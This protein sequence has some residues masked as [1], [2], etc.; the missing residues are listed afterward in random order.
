MFLHITCTKKTDSYDKTK[1]SRF[2]NTVMTVKCVKA[3]VETTTNNDWKEFNKIISNA[4][5]RVHISFQSKILCN[6]GTVYT[7]NKCS[8]AVMIRTRG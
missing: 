6:I 2:F 3:V 1:V 8:L 5:Q 7:L 4:Y